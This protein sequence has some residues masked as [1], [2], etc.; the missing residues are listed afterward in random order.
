MVV[1]EGFN[2]HGIAVHTDDLDHVAR[3]ERMVGGAFGAPIITANGHTTQPQSGF[4]VLCDLA[5]L[6]D[7]GV[8]VGTHI[9][10]PEHTFHQHRAN[11]KE[12]DQREGREGDQLYAGPETCRGQ[13]T[14]TYAADA[15]A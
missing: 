12:G 15:E 8:H 10:V 6:A 2:D 5:M 1:V 13:K 4:E 7:K 9:V 3:M 14:T 11:G